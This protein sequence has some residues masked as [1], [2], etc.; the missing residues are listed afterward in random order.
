[1]LQGTLCL[2]GEK[3]NHQNDPAMNPE[4]CNGGWPAGYTGVVFSNGVFLG[5]SST[6]RSSWP[7]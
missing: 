7:T 3:G 4:T 6:D 1:M 2:T 5:I